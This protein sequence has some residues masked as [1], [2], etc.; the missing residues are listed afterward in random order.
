MLRLASVGKPFDRRYDREMKNGLPSRTFVERVQ[1]PRRARE[2]AESPLD[3]LIG[4][5]APLMLGAAGLHGLSEA[6]H[7]IQTTAEVRESMQPQPKGQSE[8]LA[9]QAY[10]RE[11]APRGSE[12]AEPL[13]M[14]ES[15]TLTM[16]EPVDLLDPS[17]RATDPWLAR[18]FQGSRMPSS[19]QEAFRRVDRSEPTSLPPV[20]HKGGTP[21]SVPWR[22]RR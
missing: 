21:E 4:G 15:G 20:Q 5:L 16:E 22:M 3:S 10:D 1:L 12:T 6:L 2:E 18:H 7:V 8:M 9:R 11:M 14:I 19:L 17:L 13:V